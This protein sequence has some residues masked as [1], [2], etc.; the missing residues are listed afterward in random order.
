MD[1]SDTS[2]T[3]ASGNFLGI[4]NVLMQLRK[5]PYLSSA[6]TGWVEPLLGDRAVLQPSEEK[7][8][9][10]ALRVHASYVYLLD[11]KTYIKS[12]GF[13]LLQV[14][15]HPDLFEGRP[16]VSAF[17]MAPGLI[18]HLPSLA[19]RAAERDVWGAPDLDGLLLLPAARQGMSA[20]EAQA[21]QVRLIWTPCITLLCVGATNSTCMPAVGFPPELAAHAALECASEWSHM[22]C[23]FC[24]PGWTAST[25]PGWRVAPF[26]C[27][28]GM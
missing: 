3:L 13:F 23:Q 2:S 6:P 11:S 22:S 26:P 7:L 8:W 1:S 25:V 28:C 12:L 14:C 24:L 9:H 27:C 15:N 4:I 17:D 5:V 19:A 21:V 16:I 18:W 10:L 20:W